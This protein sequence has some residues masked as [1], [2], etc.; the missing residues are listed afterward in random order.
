MEVAC[1]TRC[2]GLALHLLLLLQ[3]IFGA[4]RA[5]AKEHGLEDAARPAWTP[6]RPFP[7]EMP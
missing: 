6:V 2:S 3:D 7:S 5:V 1:S 4:F